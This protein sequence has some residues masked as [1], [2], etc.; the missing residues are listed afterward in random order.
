[1]R[2]TSM[3]K[4]F[5]KL[6]NS[7]RSQTRIIYVELVM[8]FETWK[9]FITDYS[10]NSL[11]VEPN[12]LAAVRHTAFVRTRQYD[13]TNFFRECS[14][15]R[16]SNRF[17]PCIWRVL[18]IQ[19]NYGHDKVKY[20]EYRITYHQRTNSSVLLFCR[21]IM[22]KIRFYRKRTILN[23]NSFLDCRDL[24]RFTNSPRLHLRCEVYQS[25]AF[26]SSQSRVKRKKTN[27]FHLDVAP[28]Q[29][30]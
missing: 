26:A 11:F 16:T 21:S 13:R 27:N 7:T 28:G 12:F 14:V 30:A 10:A 23:V 1:M 4:L 17:T 18:Y 3:A 19:F 15:N 24:F 5:E 29:M 2:F 22:P 6:Q 9:S 20:D 8:T 25:F